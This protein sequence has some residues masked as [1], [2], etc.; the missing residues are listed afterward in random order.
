MIRQRWFFVTIL[1]LLVGLQ[2]ASLAYYLRE[3]RVLA[4]YVGRVVGPDLPASEQVKALV[5]SLKDK[6]GEGNDGYFLLPVLRFLR[7]TPL[8]VIENGGDCGDRSRLLIALL[9]LRG[10]HASKWALYNAAGE[11]K[12]AVVQAKVE[13]GEMVADPLFGIWFPKPQAGYYAIAEL[14]QDPGILPQRIAELRAKGLRP[15]AGRLEFYE[16]NDYIYT[17]ARTINWNKTFVMKFAYKVLHGI[18]G[19]SADDIGR[20]AFVE[21]PALMV[22][23]GAAALELALVFAWIILARRRKQVLAKGH[24]SRQQALLEEE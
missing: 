11:S 23:I 21:E 5:L 2:S 12:H 3:Q 20:P 1:V 18:L 16:F 22:I 13:S 7:P 17:N 8:Q 15:G 24:F 9:R 19:R 14:R 6:S 4:T 10:I